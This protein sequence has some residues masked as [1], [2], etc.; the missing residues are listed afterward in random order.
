VNKTRN[1][2]FE[3]PAGRLE[4]IL[5]IPSEPARAAAVLCHAHPLHGGVMRFKVLYRAAKVLQAAGIAVLRF[6]F[7][8]VGRSE[9]QHDHGR[10]EQEDVRSA[11]DA[12]VREI[13]DRP[14]LLGGFSFGAVMALRVGDVDD[15]A[16]AL[17][18][19][20]YPVGVVPRLE[21]GPRPKR[22]LFVQ[23][24]RDAFGAPDAIRRFVELDFPN[25]RL[26]IVPDA[27]HFFTG[28]VD[29]LARALSDWVAEE[30]WKPL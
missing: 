3:G 1:L 4:G 23:G 25:G 19:M 15:R 17:L 26:V 5:T 12:L 20:G 8:G 13:P 7:R 6:N 21:P 27:D 9:G 10:G 14:T 24:E 18:A 22:T 30:P 28:H 16:S 2:D 29:E 11:V